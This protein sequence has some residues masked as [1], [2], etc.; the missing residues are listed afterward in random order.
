MIF[1]WALV[2]ATGAIAQSGADAKSFYL[3]GDEYFRGGQYDAAIVAFTQATQ[4]DANLAEAW[5]GLARS[6]LKLGDTAGASEAFREAIARA[7]RSAPAY[8]GLAQALVAGFQRDAKASPGSL[9]EA[10]QALDAAERVDSGY[11]AIYNE[12][13]RILVLKGDTQAAAQAFEQARQRAP[14]DPVILTNLALLKRDQGE[15]N[16]ARELLEQAVAIAPEDARIRAEYGSVLAR[17]GNLERASFEIDQALRLEPENP[18]ALEA[19][20][21]LRFLRQDYP[22][23]IAA[24]SRAIEID[25]VGSPE[26][27]ALLGRAALAGH[28]PA[29]ARFHLSKAVILDERN[30]AY[31]YW[32]GRANADLGDRAGAC[33]QYAEALKLKPDSPGTRNAAQSLGCAALSREQP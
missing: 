12:R 27:Y 1:A 22:G 25:P 21:E 33:T 11:A 24:L 8:V 17:T 9:E 18:T 13:G 14:E 15:F 2:L 4:Q 3:L 7:P 5:Y 23:A 29:T 16:S 20:G 28:D 32:L 6:R 30:A 10:L 31:R 26:A 19:L